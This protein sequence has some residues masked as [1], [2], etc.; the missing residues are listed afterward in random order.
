MAANRITSLRELLH[1]FLEEVEE[2]DKAFLGEGE[3]EHGKGYGWV[4]FEGEIASEYF[5]TM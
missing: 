3:T 5:M 4:L 1:F 2:N